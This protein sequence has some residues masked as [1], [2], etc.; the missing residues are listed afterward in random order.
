LVAFHR[1]TLP[2]HRPQAVDLTI[3]PT[4]FTR[5]TPSGTRTPVPGPWNLTIGPTEAVTV[6]IAPASN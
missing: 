1:V 5:V 6:A 4:A 3:P 2:P